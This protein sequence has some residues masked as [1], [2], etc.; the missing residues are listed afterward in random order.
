MS[1]EVFQINQSS[2]YFL[3]YF[4]RI[5]VSVLYMFR[6]FII[7]FTING[8]SNRNRSYWNMFGVCYVNHSTF[9]KI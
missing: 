8:L 9:K 5:L 6:Y 2:I 4:R 7:L 3:H 1:V